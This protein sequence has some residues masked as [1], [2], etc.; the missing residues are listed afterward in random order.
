MQEQEEKSTNTE[1][2]AGRIFE[3][4]GV[5][6][7][8]AVS[9][10]CWHWL[11]TI[12]GNAGHAVNGPLTHGMNWLYATPLVDLV[13]GGPMVILFF[14]L[15]GMV[16][17]LPRFTGR[18][19]SYGRYLLSRAVRLYP[20][21]WAATALSSVVL[22]LH[23]HPQPSVSA[24]LNALLAKSLSS[25]GIVHFVVLILPFDPARLDPPLWSLEHELRVSILLPL[26]V[27]LVQRVHW[28]HILP[29]G[30]LLILAG[31]ILGGGLSL[32]WTPVAVGCFLIGVLLARHREA[33]NQRW[34]R[35]SKRSRWIVAFA[36][37]LSFWIPTRMTGGVSPLLV[38]NLVPAFGAAAI[39]VIAQGR[40]VQ[41][42]LRARLP[43]WLGRISYS[44]YVVHMVVLL[45]LIGLRPAGVPPMALAPAGI[46][47]SLVL[48]TMM[49]RQ[50][51]R[52]ALALRSRLV[53]YARTP[54]LDAPALT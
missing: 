12:P 48:A 28:R 47:L 2:R 20:V 35:M 45:M 21:A 29:L 50:I 13:A 38:A 49:E 3:L 32:A 40:G 19:V 22:L 54:A 51:E 30:I 10:M 36:A 18:N 31:S 24:W 46:A 4:D 42:R 7:L 8:A 52:P 5:R 25:S 33:T 16:L 41:R 37:L 15:S 23:T 9:V 27:I 39:I 17:A 44:L 43:A 14:V 1:N 26:L 53:R 11:L 6:G 34:A